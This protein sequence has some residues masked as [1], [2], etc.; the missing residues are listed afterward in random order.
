VQQELQP[1]LLRLRPVEEAPLFGNPGV[2]GRNPVVRRGAATPPPVSS[3][4]LALPEN[5]FTTLHMR[6]KC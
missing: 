2:A 4:A 1:L 3:S 6:K 5:R